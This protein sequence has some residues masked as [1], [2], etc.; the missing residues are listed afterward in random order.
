MTHEHHDDYYQSHDDKKQS[1]AAP[2]PGSNDLAHTACQRSISGKQ[3]L[4]YYL[5]SGKNAPLN[6]RCMC[7]ERGYVIMAAWSPHV[8]LHR[9]SQ[10]QP[11]R[12][13]LR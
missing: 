2:R 10:S 3:W 1:I 6:I 11:T 8:H 13:D 5:L 7:V 4:G 9:G 12:V